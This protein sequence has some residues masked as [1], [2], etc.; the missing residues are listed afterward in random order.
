[1]KTDLGEDIFFL[2][3]AEVRKS[4]EALFKYGKSFDLANHIEHGLENSG[5]FGD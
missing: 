4:Q 5:L 2:H 1:M 3:V